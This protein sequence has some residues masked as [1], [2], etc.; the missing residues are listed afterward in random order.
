V[1]VDLDEAYEVHPRVALRPE[2]F[3]ALAYHYDT[4]RL[5]FL[6]THDMVAV[7]N[8]LSA[9]ES[10]AIALSNAGIDSRRWPAFRRALGQLVESGMI[11]VRS[12]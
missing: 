7:V 11:R 5:S 8:G 3:G 4:R 10:V 1:D 6:R 9:S 12:E 2:P